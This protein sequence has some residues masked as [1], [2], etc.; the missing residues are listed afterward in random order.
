ME[1]WQTEPRRAANAP[2]ARLQRR[3]PARVST[4]LKPGA[5]AWAENRDTTMFYRTDEKHGLPRNPFNSIVAPRP[6]GW[7][8]TLD[9][10]GRP[11]LA[12][13]SF[14]NAVSYAPPQVIF[15]GGPRP[16]RRGDAA[17]MK[18][19]V[20]NARA[21]GEF[22]VNIATWELRER[23]NASA[24]GVAREV[25]EFALAGLT[26]APAALV[27]PP[28]VKESPIHL[29]CVT[30]AVYPTLAVPGYAP[31]LI[32]LGKVVGI[33]IDERVLTA[34]IVDQKK[35]GLIGRLGGHDYVRVGEVFTMMRPD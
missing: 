35:L 28:R 19:S 30:V 12:P 16:A 5:L 29:E 9:R 24:A 22:V 31:N 11:N 7:I 18:D 33:H 21:T 26:K 14:F 1:A 2:C 4:C 20:A 27:K 8:S 3:L 32:V 6:I 23:M 34:G 15:S 25:D 13:Y 10:A 17:P